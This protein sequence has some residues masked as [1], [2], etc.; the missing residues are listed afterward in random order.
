MDAAYKA[1]RVDYNQKPED[2]TPFSQLPDVY[3][4]LRYLGIRHAETETFEADD[5]IAGYVLAY[6]RET[7]IVIVSFDSDFFQLITDN[8]SV[9]R[10]RG[11]N[12]II[13]TPDYIW[14]K[15]GIAPE[16]YADFKS[17]TG[18][19]SDNIKG[20][21]KVGPKTAARLLNEFG[22]LENILA[23]ADAIKKPSIKDPILRNREKLLTNYKIIRLDNAVPLP[24]ILDNL[25]YS[26]TGVTT[27]DVL[28]GIGL[29]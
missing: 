3:A 24:F 29:T 9:L 5:W 6:G 22:T 13:C 17:L 1:N 26:F 18:D 10:Y 20:T 11:N 28:K 7:E 15:F 25:M 21:D 16:Q 2:E 19:T 8:V 12:T 23:N 4:A 14:D 27:N